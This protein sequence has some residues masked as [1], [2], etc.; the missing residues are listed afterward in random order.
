MILLGLDYGRSRVGL[1]IAVGSIIATRGFLDY[2]KLKGNVFS[3]I[4]NI[5]DQEKADKI[6]IGT[7]KSKMGQETEKF[8]K[9]LKLIVDLPIEM[10]DETLTS[11]E[12]EKLVGCKDKGRVDSVAAALILKR[13]LDF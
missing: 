10:V 8:I 12:A 5:A 6:I 13:Y 9:K 4:K 3:E 7:S 11:Y 2:K 1:A